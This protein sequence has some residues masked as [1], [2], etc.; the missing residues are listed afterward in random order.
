MADECW[1]NPPS[2]RSIVRTCSHSDPTFLS[3]TTTKYETE[4]LIPLEQHSPSIHI[5]P[6]TPL[7]QRPDLKEILQKSHQSLIRTHDTLERLRELGDQLNQPINISNQQEDPPVTGT[8]NYRMKNILIN[9]YE[10]DIAVGVVN[11]LYQY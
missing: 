11:P 8:P 4:P 5:E 3:N 2:N 6:T 7:P 10:T 9:Q 1:K